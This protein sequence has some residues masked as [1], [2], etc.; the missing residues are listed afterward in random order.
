MAVEVGIV[1]C[2][3]KEENEGREGIW[4]MWMPCRLGGKGE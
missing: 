3:S 4:E 1:S 2:G